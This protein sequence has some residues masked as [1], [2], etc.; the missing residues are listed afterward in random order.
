[1]AE[2]AQVSAARAFLRSLNLLVKSAR[3]YGFDHQRTT[4]Q[5]NTTFTDLKTA[6]PLSG[7]GGLT[8]GVSGTKLLVG[9]TPIDMSAVEKG[10]AEMLAAGGIA[11][12]FFAHHASLEDVRRFAGAFT[13]SGT[14]NPQL[15]EQLKTA[16]GQG[17]HSAIKV[18]EIRYV[19]SDGSVPLPGGGPGGGT[20]GGV[21]Y[22]P[23][24][25][26]DAR[27]FVNPVVAS[28]LSSDE[29]QGSLL[30]G[31]LRSVMADPKRLLQM[32]AAAEGVAQSGEEAGAGSG[33]AGGYYGGS[34]GEELVGPGATVGG[35]FPGGG[36]GT[37]AGGGVGTGVGGGGV[38]AGASGGPGV[39]G[40]G[41]GSGG[42]GAGTGGAGLAG[43]GSGGGRAVAAY[44]PTEHDVLSVIQILTRV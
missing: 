18:N 24:G 40:S 41:G 26:L 35:G 20:G 42:T 6:L 12:I 4:A 43:A 2:D 30:S 10:F 28:V 31:D 7:T 17:E 39:G 9:G 11:S 27:S 13:A 16:L 25:G 1:M 5:L 22:G 23:E 15:G 44:A 3:M 32:I 21:V 8:L 33:G 14:K 34:L 36:G 29:G 38:G 37:G 19:A